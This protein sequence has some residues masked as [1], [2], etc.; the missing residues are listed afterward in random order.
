MII[1]GTRSVTSTPERGEF[2][3]P[4]CRSAQ[5]FKLKRVRNFF[6][7]YFIPLIPLQKLGEYV[8]CEG[9]QGD[10]VVDVLNFDPNMVT[11]R[12]HEAF[13]TAL[14]RI[15]ASVLSKTQAT[16]RDQIA[17]AVAV[18]RYHANDG[19]DEDE[20]RDSLAQVNSHEPLA[21]HVAGMDGNLT[22]PAKEIII[23]LAYETGLIAGDLSEDLYQQIAE[24]AMAL[25]MTPAHFR[26]VIA[27]D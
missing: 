19:I 18:Y 12:A 22:D 4:N 23:R 14:R 6:T 27:G 1:F 20:L 25:G 13:A 3:C 11:D 24:M 15:S 9:C 2:F 21:N 8:H 26:G 7:L 17:Q 5:T 10:F 16:G